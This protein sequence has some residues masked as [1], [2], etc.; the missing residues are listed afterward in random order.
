[1]N[2]YTPTGRA[3]TA[4]PSHRVRFNPLMDIQPDKSAARIYVRPPIAITPAFLDAVLGQDPINVSLNLAQDNPGVTVLMATSSAHNRADRGPDLDIIAHRVLAYA[5]GHTAALAT[6]PA[7]F[8]N[9][10]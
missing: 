7:P 6:D 4:K 3:D 5:L 10:L 9:P 8:A 1:M 2:E